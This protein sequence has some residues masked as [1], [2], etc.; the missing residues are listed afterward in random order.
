[1]RILPLVT[2][3]LLAVSLQAQSVS[4]TPVG[5]VTLTFPQGLS[6]ISLQLDAEPVGQ[7]ET[8]S[9]GPSLIT[10]SPESW[11]DGSYSVPAAP[12]VI[13]MTS[14]AASGASFRVLGNTTNTLTVDSRG[15]DLSTIVSVGDRFS[16]VPIDTLASLFGSSSV[17]FLIG[18][19]ASSADNILLW[20]GTNWLT[21]FHNGV[22]WRR[23]GSLSNQNDTPLM[24]DAGLLVQR[25]S[26][27]TLSLVLVGKV[28][29]SAP[30]VF[31]KPN[32]SSWVTGNFPIPMSLSSLT[33]RTVPGWLDGASASAADNV[34][35]WGGESWLTF[36]HNGTTWRRSGSLANQDSFVLPAGAPYFVV[37][38]S[39]GLDS[40]S[41]ATL[42][43]P[44]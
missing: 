39:A 28:R 23:S 7:F 4:T 33:I 6:A 34:L 42:E 10:S 24:P 18:S 26:P 36:F 22:S 37:R 14:G 29:E 20:S 13:R 30:K 43:L 35:V 38:R 27:D 3:G 31:L 25:R 5:A 1:M 32:S 9:V 12:Y 41:F 2:A 17:D 8:I 19:S 40:D 16:I 15:I 11:E 21:Y 44:Y